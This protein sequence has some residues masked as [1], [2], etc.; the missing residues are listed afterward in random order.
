[1]LKLPALIAFNLFA[2]PSRGAFLHQGIIEVSEST[3]RGFYDVDSS[4]KGKAMSA[5]F[6]PIAIEIFIQGLRY[7]SILSS[8]PD[9][10]QVQILKS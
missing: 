8:K 2:S 1:M 10:Q 9:R 4:I 7:R 3:Y 5:R 6:E